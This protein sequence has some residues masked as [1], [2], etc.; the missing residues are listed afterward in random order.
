MPQISQ[1]TLRRERSSSPPED[2]PKSPVIVDPSHVVILDG[3]DNVLASA[4]PSNVL[5][6]TRPPP[7]VPEQLPVRYSREGSMNQHQTN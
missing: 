4:P 6:S 5:A 1:E 2:K 7:Y 3:E